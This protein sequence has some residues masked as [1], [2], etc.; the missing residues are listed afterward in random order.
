MLV[1]GSRESRSSRTTS[2]RESNAGSILVNFVMWP[3][4]H[5][6]ARGSNGRDMFAMAAID[7]K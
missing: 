6:G 5:D 2:V 3:G 7:A 4:Y 1:N